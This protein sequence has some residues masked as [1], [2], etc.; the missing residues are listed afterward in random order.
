MIRAHNIHHV[1][2]IPAPGTWYIVP[3]TAVHDVS[4]VAPLTV[5]VARYKYRHTLQEFCSVRFR[6]PHIRTGWSTGP[7][8]IFH[9]V[10]KKKTKVATCFLLSIPSL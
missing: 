7:V 8:S 5:P 10:S 2:Y 3:T 6:L 9:P 4:I 1:C